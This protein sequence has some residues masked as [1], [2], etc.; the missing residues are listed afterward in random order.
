VD[1]FFARQQVHERLAEAVENLPSTSGKPE[2][3]PISTG[4]G[5]IF[6][7]VVKDTTGRLSPMDLR[8]VQDWI[9]RKQLQG[10]PG[11]AEINSLGGEV[12]QVHVLVNPV[13]LAGWG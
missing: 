10:V 8:T 6:R 13:S 9:V 11:L 7:Y 4:L 5:E 1:P 2:L 3:A 12:K